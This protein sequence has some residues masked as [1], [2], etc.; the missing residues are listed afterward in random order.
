[1]KSLNYI[2]TIFALILAVQGCSSSKVEVIGEKTDIKS[3]EG[4]WEGS[5]SNPNNG[6]S[7]SIS[8]TLKA[9]QDSAT[10]VVIMMP[11][12]SSAPYAHSYKSEDNPQP[13]KISFVAVSGGVIRGK[14]DPYLDPECNCTIETSFEGTVKKNTVEGTFY[15]KRAETGDASSGTWNVSRQ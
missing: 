6:R 5:Y 14:L 7:G 4:K 10:G 8:F 15:S 9:G 1:M 12:G 13:L 11:H 2:I 3:I